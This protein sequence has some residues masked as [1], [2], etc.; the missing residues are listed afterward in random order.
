MGLIITKLN[1]PTIKIRIVIVMVISL[2]YTFTLLYTMTRD[3]SYLNTT[4]VEV[5]PTSDEQS[6]PGSLTTTNPM[7]DMIDALLAGDYTDI[8]EAIASH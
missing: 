4:R 1:K 3:H 7:D 5:Q 2:L 8:S 6:Q